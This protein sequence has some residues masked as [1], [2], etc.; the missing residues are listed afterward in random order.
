MQINPTIWEILVH[1]GPD[2]VPEHGDQI[3]HRLS[4]A[5]FQGSTTKI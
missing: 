2:Q 5:R 3:T 4:R 1:Q